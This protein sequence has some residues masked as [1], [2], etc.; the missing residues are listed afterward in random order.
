MAKWHGKKNETP[1]N[2]MEKIAQQKVTQNIKKILKN[3]QQNQDSKQFKI[4]ERIKNF[5]YQT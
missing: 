1:K 5:F 2:G 3:R 4:W